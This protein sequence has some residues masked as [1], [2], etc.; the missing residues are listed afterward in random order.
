MDQSVNYF[1]LKCE[2]NWSRLSII[3][4]VLSLSVFIKKKGMKNVIFTI[5]FEGI[6]EIYPI[7]Y[8]RLCICTH[9]PLQL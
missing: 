1:G 8:L 5:N 3:L 9:F 4:I 7:F 6:I 2:L